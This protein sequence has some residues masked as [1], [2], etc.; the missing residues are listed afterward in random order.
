MK[1][2]VLILISLFLISSNC[3]QNFSILIKP[4]SV[5]TSETKKE[6][7]INSIKPLS[8]ENST[9]LQKCDSALN[10]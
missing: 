10:M 3:L 8:Q 2:L 1:T 9:I 6:A 4:N 7:I 5:E